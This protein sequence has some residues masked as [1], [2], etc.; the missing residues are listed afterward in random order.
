MD[1]DDIDADNDAAANDD[2]DCVSMFLYIRDTGLEITYA[3][4]YIRG[5]QIES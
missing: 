4:T 2:A 3:Y 1:N 5:K